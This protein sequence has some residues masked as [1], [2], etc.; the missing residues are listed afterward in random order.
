MLLLATLFWGASFPLMK[1]TGQLVTAAVPAASLWFATAMMILPRFALAAL[2]LAVAL[3]RGLRG[4]TGREWQQGAML[5]GFA[6]L[7]MILQADGLHYTAASTSAFLSQFYA[8]LIPLW[9]AWRTRRN[10]GRRVWASTGLVLIGV[11]VLGQFDWQAMRLGRGEAETLLASVF[12]TGQIL[13]LERREF[14]LNRV[15]PITFVMFLVQALVFGV[16]AG[17]TA[18]SP[19]AILV[20]AGSAAWWGFTLALT[21]FCTLGSFLIM[22]TWQPR[23]PATEAGLLYCAEPVFSALMTL[24]LPGWFSLWAGIGYPNEAITLH[25]LIGG[26]F[27]LGANVLLQLRR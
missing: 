15:L 26:G 16:L 24:F 17:A 1:A 9:M 20:P 8:I 25:L 23:V 7:G 21:G 14:A 4:I 11:A 5:G 19:S 18:P 2:I 27:I 10:P 6:A 22:N 13:T 12:F 3:G